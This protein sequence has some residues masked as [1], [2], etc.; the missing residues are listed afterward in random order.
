MK[1]FFTDL[2]HFFKDLFYVPFT[3]KSGRLAI[4]YMLFAA[5]LI[6][7]NCIAAWQIPVIAGFK[8]FGVTEVSITAGIIF[9]PFTFLITD[10]IGENY[11]RRAANKAVLGGFI[12]QVAVILVIVI[13]N[14]IMKAT[15]TEGQEAFENYLAGNWILTLGSLLACIVSQTWDVFIFHKLRDN[16]IKKHGST[17]GGK[18]IWNNL[19]TIGSQLIDSVIFYIGFTIFNNVHLAQFGV[20]A[21]TAEKFFVT[22]LVYWVIKIIIALLDTPIFYALTMGH[23]DRMSVTS[24]HESDVSVL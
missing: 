10:I 4:L 24:D 18:W 12:G 9:Y 5:S 21:M 2:G 3:K 17:K 14:A 8:W 1:K 13:I 11:G 16:Y 19:S 20:P 23:K 6:G 7:A 15:G 22:L